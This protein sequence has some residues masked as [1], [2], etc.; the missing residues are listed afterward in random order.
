MQLLTRKKQTFPTQPITIAFL[1]SPFSIDFLTFYCIFY[2]SW[3]VCGLCRDLGGL[4]AHSC[5]EMNEG[6]LWLQGEKSGF[7]MSLEGGHW[8][9][10]GARWRDMWGMVCGRKGP[11]GIEK[12]DDDGRHEGC[13]WVAQSSPFWV[14]VT[15]AHTGR[16]RRQYWM[17]A[18]LLVHLH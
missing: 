5:F 4:W 11:L 17:S 9:S 10:T 15:T 3:V 8:G 14:L 1:C 16:C 12:S 2:V 6:C 7:N 13:L 18:S